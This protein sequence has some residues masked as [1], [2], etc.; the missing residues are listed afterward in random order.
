MTPEETAVVGMSGGVDS[1]VAAALLREQGYRVLGLTMVFLEDAPL[2]LHAKTCCS[3]TAVQDAR[4]VCSQLGVEHYV[5]RLSGA[6][7]EK[8]IEPFVA[9]Y[10]RG[11]TPNPC[12]RC[13]AEIRFRVLREF[14][15]RHGARRIAT[16]H[17][18]RTS[19]SETSRRY[20]LLRAKAAEKDQSYMLYRLSQA[21]LSATL[22]PL[23]EL[24]GKSE[25]R[26][27]ARALGL[28]V[29]HRP[30]SQDI[31]FV[32]KGGYRTLLRA[33]AGERLRPGPIVDEEGNVLGEHRGLALYT[34][35]Q[36]RGLPASN[37]GPLYVTRLDT[38]TN[39]LHVGTEGALYASGLVAE[40]LNWVSIEE[41]EGELAVSVCIR[42]NAV[43]IP[44]ELTVRSGVAE[45]R[46]ERPVRAVTPGQAA[47]FYEGDRVLGGGVIREVFGRGGMDE[48]T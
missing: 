1:A 33:A 47:V 12:T 15:E 42:Y 32:P 44:A 40:D 9:E 14:A 28:S 29:A 34:V 5:V 37:R 19:Y 13:N 24:S 3:L 7:Q 46:F 38:R 26:G 6:F 27:I 17:Y 35:G 8:V 45:C 11:R 41:P 31:C 18:A 20:E 36:R 48:R 39:T 10:L 2:G 21:D 16:G 4:S 23:G 22:F 30:E 43:A 25:T